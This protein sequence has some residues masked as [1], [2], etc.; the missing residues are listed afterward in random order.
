MGVVPRPFIT[1]VILI[2]GPSLNKLNSK[3]KKNSSRVRAF[4][5]RDDL[6]TKTEK[7]IGMRLNSFFIGGDLLKREQ[8]FQLNEM[9]QKL[10]GKV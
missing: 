4:R 6:N 7:K 8:C 2:S 1:S 5:K 10:W 9:K 3:T